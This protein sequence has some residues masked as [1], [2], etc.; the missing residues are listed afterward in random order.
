[1]K[2]VSSVIKDFMGATRSVPSVINMGLLSETSASS[3]FD[4]CFSFFGR[5]IHK[6]GSQSLEI[7]YL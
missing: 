6:S 1:M 4:P 7:I 2:I 5:V 3:L